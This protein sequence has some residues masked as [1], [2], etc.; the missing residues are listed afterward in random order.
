MKARALCFL[1]RTISERLLHSE[2]RLSRSTELEAP[3]DNHARHKGTAYLS[4][5][6]IRA[7]EIP[8]DTPHATIDK[9][10]TVTFGGL[11]EKLLISAQ[12][13]VFCVHDFR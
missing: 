2:L 3:L 9:A 13:C 11:D 5:I 7:C 4:T 8:A 12:K 6:Y 1:S 10:N